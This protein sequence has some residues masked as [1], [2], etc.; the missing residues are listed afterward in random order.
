MGLMTVLSMVFVSMILI[1]S[2]TPT[3]FAGFCSEPGP[4]VDCDG[5]GFTPN[6]GDCNDGSPETFPGQG[7]PIPPE[8]AVEEIVDQVVNMVE[9]GDLEINHGQTNAILSKL[10]KA[11]DK[12]AS[13]NTN[14]AIG[15]LKAFINQINA[16]INSGSIS[17][18]N[19]KILIDAAQNIINNL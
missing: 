5:D 10:D 12:F 14:A 13:G 19:A 11:V 16:Y 2:Q 15:A 4:D 7:C 9:S 3:A 6:E 18:E 17:P 1:T 8:P